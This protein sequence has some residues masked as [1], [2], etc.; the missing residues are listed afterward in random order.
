MPERSP[1]LKAP[2]SGVFAVFGA[3]GN[4]KALAVKAYFRRKNKTIS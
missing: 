3:R 2:K 4:F 1:L